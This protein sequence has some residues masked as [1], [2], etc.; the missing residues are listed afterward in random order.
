MRNTKF[1][2]IDK[3]SQQNSNFKISLLFPSN[4]IIY[5]LSINK[6]K[7]K[8]KKVLFEILKKKKKYLHASIQ[9][10]FIRSCV[11]KYKILFRNR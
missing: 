8:K 5:L 11:L 9:K 10:P 1:S 7:K 6:K 4:G 2:S 3:I